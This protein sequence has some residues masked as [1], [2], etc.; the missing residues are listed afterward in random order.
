MRR[1][2][3]TRLQKTLKQIQLRAQLRYGRNLTH[4]E[5]AALAGVGARSFGDWMR[6]VS[7]PNG[8]IAVFELLSKLSGAD[9]QE[10]LQDWKKEN[11]H[12]EFPDRDQIN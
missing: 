4:E 8:M 12:Q 1:Q 3:T 11:G 2:T 10:I 5:M 6:G 9:V 7:A